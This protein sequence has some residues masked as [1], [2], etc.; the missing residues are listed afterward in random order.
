MK[1]VILSFYFFFF[2]SSLIGYSQVTNG[3]NQS[4]I[5]AEFLGWNNLGFPKSLDI[6][7]NFTNQPINFFTN[8]LQRMTILGGGNVGLGTAA[9]VSLFHLNSATATAIHGRFTNS[10]TGA[11]ATDG[12]RFG[13]EINGDFRFTQFEN[14]NTDIWTPD[15]ALTAPIQRFRI[16]PN[17]QVFVGNGTMAENVI[18]GGTVANFGRTSL[19]NVRGPINSCGQMNNLSEEPTVLYGYT[20]PN[21]AVAPTGDGF[22]M[23]MNFTFRSGSSYDALVFEKTDFNGSDPDGYI[24]FTNTG[25]DGVEEISTYIDGRGRMYIGDS[26]IAPLT[27]RFTI[28]SR[29]GDAS[30]SGLRFVDLTSSATPVSNPGSGVLSVNPQGNV[31]YVNAPPSPDLGNYC[32]APTSNPLTDN[33][34]IP[35]NDQNVYFENNNLLGQN[36]VGFGYAC[37]SILPGKIS[38]TQVHPF[39]ITSSG[40]ETTAGYFRNRDESE[41]FFTQFVA[42][43]G[44]ADGFNMNDGSRNVGGYF[45]AN[46][47]LQSVGVVG[48]G[49]G[50]KYS[51]G[52]YGEALNGT[53]VNYGVYGKATGTNAWAGWFDGPGFLGAGAWTYSD[54]NLKQNIQEFNEANAILS[55][56]NPVRY[57][58][59]TTEYPQLNLSTTPQIGLIAQELQQ[60]LPDAVRDAQTP[61]K[62]DSFGNIIEESVAFKAVSYEKLIPV[63]VGGHQEQQSK[64]E[65]L[66]TENDLLKA[67]LDELYAKFNQLEAC[68]TNR[69][70]DLC[71]INQGMIQQNSSEMQQQIIQSIDVN[72]SSK[73]SI[74]LNQNVP[75]PFAESTVISYSIPATVVKAQIH[76]YDGQGKLINSVEITNRGAGQLNV[77]GEDLSSGTYTYT[78]VADG[79]IIS[80]KK[81]VKE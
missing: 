18:D 53:V 46:N 4:T 45:S 17:G 12:T 33:Y 30:P 13:I 25:N 9:P 56:L 76:F 49:L 70:P 34:Q 72:L 14:R 42:V 8:N 7:N 69:F 78:L 54:Y 64:I 52:V 60:V 2:M 51:V 22:R 19:L 55:Q 44:E 5:N 58:F 80:T 40:T 77:F 23:H 66:Q 3:T 71:R 41:T 48:T 68:L 57:D 10:N 29:P 39:P 1:K 16:Q 61:A 11:T 37:S 27:N 36:H 38:V 43:R 67:Q 6:R 20:N 73:N 35:M 63:L 26:I 75:N 62:Y 24:A 47:G 59:K 32:S 21:D 79:Q 15:L 65:L 28:D 81:M 74:I 50:G 31:I